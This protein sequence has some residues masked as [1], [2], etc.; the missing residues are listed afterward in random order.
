VDLIERVENLS[1]GGGGGSGIAGEDGATFTP[2]VSTEGII[3]WTNDKGLANPESVNIKGPQGP[4]GERGLQGEQGKQGIQ[5]EKGEKGDTGAN[6]S[7]GKDG[8]NGTDGVGIKSVVQTTTSSADGGSN[9]ITVTKTDNT[10]S[11]FTV[12]NGSKGNKGDKGDTGATGSKGADGYTPIKGIDYFTEADKAEIVTAVIESLGGNPVFGYV[13][14]NNTVVLNGNLADGTYN[15]KYEMAD[16]STI[17]IGDLVLDN[18]VYYSITNNLTNCTNGNGVT[19]IVKDGTYS[20]TISANSGY[21]LSSVVV[22]MGGTD[23][24]SSAVSGETINIASVT[25]NIVITAVATETVVTP[26]YTNLAEPNETNTSDWDLWI[27]NARIGSDGGYRSGTLSV[28]NWISIANNNTFCAK[29]ITYPSDGIIAFYDSNKAKI[30]NVGALS[31]YTANGYAE[32]VSYDDVFAFK[33]KNM[34]N[35]AFVRFG[36]TVSGSFDDVIMTVNELI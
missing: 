26:T 9:V 28:N 14:E 17:D 1:G 16:G 13:D 7:N 6:G 27:N 3:S 2:N 33:V 18:N 24:T 35:V 20:A 10:T 29:G 21:E 31:Y 22:T 25:G 11:T 36:F 30:G 8:S 12:K 15:I 32:D 23:I 5:G 4:Q 34:T 19:Q